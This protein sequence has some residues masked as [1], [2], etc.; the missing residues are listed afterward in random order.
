MTIGIVAK[1]AKGSASLDISSGRYTVRDFIPP[2]AAEVNETASGLS[3]NRYGGGALSNRRG[4][5][6]GLSISIRVMGATQ[7]EVERGVEDMIAFLRL[8]G[9]EAEPLYL[10]WLPNSYVPYKPMWGQAGWKRMDIKSARVERSAMFNAYE[11]RGKAQ[12]A[13][14]SAETGPYPLGLNQRL[15]TA[16]GGVF[17]DYIGSATGISKG[18]WIPEATVNKAANPVFGHVTFGNGWTAGAGVTAAA[19]YDKRFRLFDYPSARL[20][21]TTASS[22]SSDDSYT[23]AVTYTGASHTISLYVKKPDS[24]AVTASD[25]KVWWGGGQTSTYQSLGDGWYR[26]YS[27]VSASAE[28]LA[29]GIEL[30]TVGAG[31]YLAAM[32]V[33]A[34][35]YPTLLCHGD[36]MGCVWTAATAHDDTSTR[37]AATMSIDNAVSFTPIAGTVRAVLQMDCDQTS[38]DFTI[39]QTYSAAAKFDAYYEADDD[40][41]YFSDGTNTI[42]SA[43]QTWSIGDKIVLHFTWKAGALR[44]YKNGAVIATGDTY[45]PAATGTLMYVGCDQ[46]G[47]EQARALWLDFTTYD[48]S[49]SAAEVLADYT[50]V[51]Q[52]AADGQRV[53]F[54][55]WLHNPAPATN[56]NALTCAGGIPGDVDADTYIEVGSPVAQAMEDDCFINLNA[57]PR[58]SSLTAGGINAI[59]KANTVAVTVTTTAIS[60]DSSAPN[61][62]YAMRIR[63][64]KENYYDKRAWIWFSYADAGSNLLFAPAMNYTVSSSA[65]GV[66]NVS[67]GEYK[68]KPATFVVGPIRMPRRDQTAEIINRT[69]IQD[70]IV[71]VMAIRTT[72]TGD[73]TPVFWQLLVGKMAFINFSSTVMSRIML[74]GSRAIGHDASYLTEVLNPQ[75]DLIELAPNMINH[76]V[77]RNYSQVLQFHKINIIPRYLLA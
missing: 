26:V 13:L 68:T 16:A 24:S 7:A 70:I 10:E 40:K 58:Y 34:K 60:M 8:A 55:P 64:D 44:I 56:Q 15:A 77:I 27:T 54:I 50:N 75:G 41:F 71:Y 72:G 20:I 59:Y 33:E 66:Y 29:T 28:A 35:A 3:S 11:V 14:I 1:L 30:K 22:A 25:C 69:I 65:I 76:L 17:E 42:T 73:V 12:I 43:A 31:L 19:N 74:H 67:I 4:V 61:Y 48:I 62:T 18:L 36:M 39:F 45:T 53:G 21:T 5:N 38:A 9:D 2:T 51:S 52:I 46:G 49:L 63:Y 47:A 6:G 32:Q 57:A 23:A 37:T